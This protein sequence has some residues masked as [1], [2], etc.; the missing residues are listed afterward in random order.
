MKFFYLLVPFVAFASGS[1]ENT[2]I[3]VRVINFAI[4]AGILYYL[5]A[6]PVRAAYNARIERIAAGLSAAEQKAK[7]SEAEKDE[8][9][10]RL[11]KAEA[12]AKSLVEVAQNEARIASEKVAK[13]AKD[14][15]A[16]L[17]KSFEE[18]KKL[19]EK[20]ATRKTVNSVLDDIFDSSVNSSEQIFGS[21]LKKV[22]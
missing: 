9:L 1:N 7:Q 3:V 4:F 14:E 17:T 18:K 22:S 15:V 5:I 13:E 21:I 6:K 2:D 11:T 16:N 10:K 12:D 19:E 20:K 8:A